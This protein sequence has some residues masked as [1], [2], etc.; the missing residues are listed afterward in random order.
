MRTEHFINEQIK[1]TKIRISGE[2]ELITYSEAM[3]RANAEGA[4][5]I[6]ISC[7]ND[8]SICV[9]EEYSKFLYR[10]KK[11]SKEKDKA[12]AKPSMKEMK[13]GLNIGEHDMNHKA[14][15][16]IELME[17]GSKVKVSLFLSG[18]EI[19]RANDGIKLV[20]E[21]ITKCEPCICDKQPKLDGKI[22]S[23]VIFRK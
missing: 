7:A 12:K 1:N 3:S 5:L 16:T 22:I 2:K 6:E 11:A 20:N 8:V 14:K 17:E 21:F 10:Q 4:D 23:A 15:K 13:L 18:R 9:I 19:V